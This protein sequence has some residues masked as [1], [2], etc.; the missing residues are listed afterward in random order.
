[1]S[2]QTQPPVGATSTGAPAGVGD[3]RLPELAERIKHDHK[4]IRDALNVKNLVPKAIKIGEWLIEA[5]LKLDH[6]QWLP[7][8]KDKC[9]LS[10]RTSSRYMSLHNNKAKLEEAQK[11]KS[12]TLADMTLSDADKIISKA[13]GK[14][15]RGSNPVSTANADDVTKLEDKMIEALKKMDGIVAQETVAAFLRRLRDADLLEK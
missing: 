10:D 3:N 11:L 7:Y 12:A 4:A 14:K 8:L 13:N 1:M 5:K 15:P 9:G 2:T 6:G